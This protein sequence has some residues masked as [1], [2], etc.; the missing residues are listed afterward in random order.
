MTREAARMTGSRRAILDELRMNGSHPTADEIHERLRRKLPRISLATVYRN[1]DYLERHGLIRVV[2]E[3][4]GR[5][6]YDAAQGSHHHLWCTSCGR[7]KDVRLAPDAKVETLL[8]D[9]F[10]YTIDGCSLS[11]LGTCPECAGRDDARNA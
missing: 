11:F 3:P 5:R 4:G 10:G 1:L 2:R 9:A 7:V 6:R 8:E